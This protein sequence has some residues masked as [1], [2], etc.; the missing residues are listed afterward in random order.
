MTQFIYYF[1]LFC[2]FQKS[3][4]N[5]I[6]LYAQTF[7]CCRNNYLLVRVSGLVSHTF[8]YNALLLWKVSSS[9][10][11]DLH[12]FE[13][14]LTEFVLE[15]IEFL[16]LCA[17]LVISWIMCIFYRTLYLLHRAIHGTLRHLPASKCSPLLPPSVIVFVITHPAS[18]SCITKLIHERILCFWVTPLTK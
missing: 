15:D 18:L 4:K 16:L 17:L 8:K 1:Y 3:N 6:Y 7:P 12:E 2:N 11:R 5:M 14:C 10:H 9:V 13:F